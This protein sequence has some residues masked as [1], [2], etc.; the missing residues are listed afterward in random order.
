MTLPQVNQSQ[1]DIRPIDWT[2]LPT[3]F[4]NPG[5]LEVLIALVRDVS[6]TAV[7]EFG[8]NVGRTAKALLSNVETID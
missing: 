5:E 2:G 3:R 7:I 1:F 8:V 6:P 4:L